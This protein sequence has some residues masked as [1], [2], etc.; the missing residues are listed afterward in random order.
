MFQ[1][2][3]IS[4]QLSLQME[5]FK[6]VAAGARSA[7]ASGGARTAGLKILCL[8]PLSNVYKVVSDKNSDLVE[9]GSK[10]VSN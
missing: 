3:P 5:S 6:R 4:I 1:T 10:D 8:C 7:T 9:D 2:F